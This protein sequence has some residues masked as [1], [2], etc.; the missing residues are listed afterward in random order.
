MGVD[1]SYSNSQEL[2]CFIAAYTLL[3]LLKIILSKA[4][5]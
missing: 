5:H 4:F 3:I 2:S 1:G